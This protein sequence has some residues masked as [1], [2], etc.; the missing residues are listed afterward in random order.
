MDARRAIDLSSPSSSSSSRQPLPHFTATKK[1]ANPQTLDSRAVELGF[2]VEESSST[3]NFENRQRKTRN[4][5]WEL[6]GERGAL[7]FV[8][9]WTQF[10][11]AIHFNLIWQK[12]IK[13]N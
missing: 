3:G 8:E 4:L 2:R 10:S 1:N 9:F 13:L 5:T 7:K 11:L 12:I 6:S